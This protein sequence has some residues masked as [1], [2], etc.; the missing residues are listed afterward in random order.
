MGET[1]GFSEGSEV[2]GDAVLGAGEV[3]HSSSAFQGWLAQH[4]SIVSNSGSHLLIPPHGELPSQ[5]WTQR[6]VVRNMYHGSSVVGLRVGRRVG[7][8]DCLAVGGEV[9]GLDVGGTKS[10][11]PSG[12]ML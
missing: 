3:S 7:L 9:V 2:V 12:H 5:D 8:G 1:V 11:T 10:S 4:S 6:P